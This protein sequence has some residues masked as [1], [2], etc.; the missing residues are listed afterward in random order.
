MTVNL[1]VPVVRDLRFEVVEAY[2][3][4]GAAGG[5][6]LLARR[7]LTRSGVADRELSLHLRETPG[8]GGP[9][10]AVPSSVCSR[11]AFLDGESVLVFLDDRPEPGALHLVISWTRPTVFE[12]IE[13]HL[14]AVLLLHQ[15]G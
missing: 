1:Q 13:G 14:D 6:V 9:F 7:L 12:H 15:F 3:E 2:D 8:G 10:V 11:V 4:A 5:L